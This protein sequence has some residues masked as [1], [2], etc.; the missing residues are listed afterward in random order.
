M[1]NKDTGIVNIHGKEYQ[2]VAHRVNKFR[3]EY[4]DYSILTEVISNSDKVVVMKATILNDK[5]TAVASGHAEEVRGSTNINKTSALENCETSAIGRALACFGLLGTEF[6][7]ADEV[8]H[9]ITSKKEYPKPNTAPKA[10]PAP[11]V[12]PEASEPLS[13][14]EMIVKIK[15]ANAIPHL[16]NIWNKY[17]P[18]YNFMT[19]SDQAKVKQAKEVK[20]AELVGVV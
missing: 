10:K 20:K 19:E 5:F 15:E 13:A 3:A 12:T 2:T 11:K 18:D 9:A 14:D 16:K 17:A 4:K 7:S 8:Q 1:A 6:A